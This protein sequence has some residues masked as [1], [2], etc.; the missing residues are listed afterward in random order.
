[1]KKLALFIL[2]SEINMKA[3]AVF[4]IA[5]FPGFSIFGLETAKS[6]TLLWSANARFNQFAGNPGGFDNEGLGTYQLMGGR[7]CDFSC[8]KCFNSD[9]NVNPIGISSDDPVAC[10]IGDG[11]TATNSNQEASLRPIS[12]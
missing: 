7:S 4:M 8:I 1:L 9:G 12:L 3:R 10:D 6:A 2:K 11:F 5:F